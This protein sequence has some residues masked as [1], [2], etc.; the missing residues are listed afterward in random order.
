MEPAD[1]IF[2]GELLARFRKRQ[3]LTQQELAHRIAANRNTI[4]FW[5]RGLYKPETVTTLHELARVLNLDEEE[6]RLL[7]EAHTGTASILPLYHLPTQR[8]PYFTGRQEVLSLLHGK[9]KTGKQVALNQAI[10]GLGG[11][12]KTQVAL[13][14]T[15]RYREHYHDILWVCAE[16]HE[17]LLASYTEIARCLR[18]HERDASDQ[19]KVVEAVKRWLR[20]HKGW[21]MVLD[22][23]EDLS[24]V[25]QLLPVERQGAVLLTTRRQVTEP[26]A[27]AIELDELSQEEGTLFL[28]KRTKRLGPH[29]VLE[30]AQASEVSVSRAITEQLGGLPLALDQAGAYRQHPHRASSLCDHD[31]D[32]GL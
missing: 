27:Q 25:S 9:L 31:I 22:N 4:S 10:S 15:Y 1:E 32:A 26:V 18:L 29:A 6:K 5:E 23:L 20:E 14:Y 8:N 2:F 17:T 21:L 11:I 19:T 30:E 28:L 12:G 3:G 13:E 7:F 24:L 16:T